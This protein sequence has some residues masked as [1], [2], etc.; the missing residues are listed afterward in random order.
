MTD[1]QQALRAALTATG[2]IYGKRSDLLT[3][4]EIEAL[5]VLN[6]AAHDYFQ[7]EGDR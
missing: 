3:A 5:V 6:I 1:S 4:E 7:R 2:G